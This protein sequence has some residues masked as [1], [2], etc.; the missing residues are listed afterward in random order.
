MNTR[1]TGQLGEEEAVRFLQ[2]KGYRILA[3]NVLARGG[4]LDIVASAHNTLVFAIDEEMTTLVFVEV[5]TRAYSSF[6]GPLAA[7]T[8]AK[9]QRLGRAAGQY[10]KEN[11]LK[12]DSIRFDVICVLPAGI[13]HIENAFSPARTT[14]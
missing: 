1:T 7:V 6:G 12:F 4:E 9:Q 5:K 14:L 3:R 13:E 10:I 2:A 11:G 8:H